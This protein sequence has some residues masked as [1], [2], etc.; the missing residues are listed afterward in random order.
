MWYEFTTV[1]EMDTGN[2]YAQMARL[3]ISMALF[4]SGGLILAL[5]NLDI[6]EY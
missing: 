3:E 5:R 6:L 2:M 4:G 1:G